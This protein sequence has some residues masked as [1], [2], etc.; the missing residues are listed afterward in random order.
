MKKLSALLLALL[1]MTTCAFALAENTE[2]IPQLRLEDME[3]LGQRWVTRDESGTEIG[4]AVTNAD[5][6]IWT[7][8][9][10]N[11]DLT[12]Y[13]V[14]SPDFMTSV[15]Y[16]IYGKILSIYA[17]TEDGASYYYDA[18]TDAW[19]QWDDATSD[20]TIVESAPQVD[21]SALPPLMVVEESAA[22]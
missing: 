10:L 2:F 16:D 15:T 7:Y 21:V 4:Y 5:Q 8:Y 1:L 17:S 22:E 20:Y 3:K 12:S 13:D 11:G 19:M 18:A 14:S 9:D 6:S